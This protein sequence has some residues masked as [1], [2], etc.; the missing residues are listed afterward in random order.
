MTS[1]QRIYLMVVSDY[2][3]AVWYKFLD[4][5]VPQF[6]NLLSGGIIILSLGCY[7]GWI[8]S[9][10]KRTQ[11]QCLEFFKIQKTTNCIVIFTPWTLFWLICHSCLHLHFDVYVTSKFCFRPKWYDMCF[12]ALFQ[13]GLRHNMEQG[14]R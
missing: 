1:D 2:F 13:F 4:L 5:S 14:N 12:V 3:L 7:D 10:R 11:R 6:P 8:S 9:Y